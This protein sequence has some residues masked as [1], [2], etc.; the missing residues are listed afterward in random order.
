MACSAE[1]MP[2][3]LDSWPILV[4]TAGTY[5]LS[6]A[7]FNWAV[8]ASLLY[9]ICSL[10][11]IF[12]FA[13]DYLIVA[14][15]GSGRRRT[16]QI[17]RIM[18]LFGLLSVP[19]KWAKAKGGFKTEFVGYLFVWDKLLG[20]LTDRRASWLAAWAERIADAGSA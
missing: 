13:E 11:Y 12:R 19:S 15:S 10:A 6:S 5:G 14:S 7:S 1:P 9:Y 17:A 4:N 2:Q 8:V 3:D 18:A 16:F 20:G